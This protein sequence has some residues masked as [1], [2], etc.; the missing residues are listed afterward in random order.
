MQLLPHALPA[1]HSLQQT[2]A[3]AVPQSGVSAPMRISPLIRTTESPTL[4]TG[5]FHDRIR[6]R[7]CK[8][9]SVHRPAVSRRTRG[10]MGGHSSRRRIAPSLKQPTR[11]TGPKPPCPERRVIP[12]RSCSR[13]GLPCR[14]PLPE[15]R[16]AL[17]APFHCHAAEAQSPKTNATC[18]LLHCPWG[19]PRRMLSGTVVSWSPDFPRPAC[20]GR[21]RPT[22]WPGGYREVRRERKAPRSSLTPPLARHRKRGNTVLS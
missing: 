21:G 14:L 10:R 9:G 2:V 12:I 13:W 3:Y 1:L 20:A 7:V 11:T 17:T 5:S 4:I 22:L 18:S 8:P 15:T 16:C 19:R 6:Q